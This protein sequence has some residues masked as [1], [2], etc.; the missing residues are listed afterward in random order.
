MLDEEA[1]LSERERYLLEQ[2]R[3]LSPR[4]QMMIVEYTEKVLSDEQAIRGGEPVEAPQEA[5]EQEWVNP[6]HDK[7]RG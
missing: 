7:K 5:E 4:A 2:F 3:K 6:I 1:L